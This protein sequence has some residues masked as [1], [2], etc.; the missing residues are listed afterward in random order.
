MIHPGSRP[1]IFLQVSDL[2]CPY[3]LQYFIQSI[4]KVSNLLISFKS[5]DYL[6]VNEYFL[7][8]PKSFGVDRVEDLEKPSS[9]LQ[10]QILLTLVHP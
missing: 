1:F 4:L 3:L 2:G 5:I 10:V 8:Q 6:N 9:G 7:E